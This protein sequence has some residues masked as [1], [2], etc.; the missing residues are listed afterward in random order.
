MEKEKYEL[1]EEVIDLLDKANASKKMRDRLVKLPF[2][3]KKAMRC[4]IDGERLTREF[5]SKVRVLYPEIQDKPLSVDAGNK[6]VIVS[7]EK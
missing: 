1:P 3:F 4:A 7:K 6:H 5:W 2:G